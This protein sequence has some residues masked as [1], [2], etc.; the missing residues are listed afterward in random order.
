M[1][2]ALDEA[3]KA[4]G[5]LVFPNPRVGAVIVENEEVIAT[6]YHQKAGEGHAEINALNALAGKL[7][8]EAEMYVTL[9][10]CSTHGRT[11]ACS[12]A[13]LMAGLTKLYVGCI[14]PNPNHAGEGIKALRAAGVE[15]TVGLLQE[16][17]EALIQDFADRI[18]AN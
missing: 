1:Q 3:M 2:M 7:S 15:V 8:P 18:I 9:E 4:D 5:E 14:D 10:P 13:L 6:G 16:K 12:D 11:G 17:C